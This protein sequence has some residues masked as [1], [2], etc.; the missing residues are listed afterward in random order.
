MKIRFFLFKCYIQCVGALIIFNAAEI[1]IHFCL[2]IAADTC[3]HTL[4]WMLRQM[5]PVM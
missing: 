4:G 5:I 3:N 1:V 2:I